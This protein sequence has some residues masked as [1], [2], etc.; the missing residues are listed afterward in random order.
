METTIKRPNNNILFAAIVAA[1]LLP[2]VLFWFKSFFPHNDI[3]NYLFTIVGSLILFAIAFWAIRNDTVSLEEI[4]WT[5]KHL[6]QA[7]WLLFIGWIIFSAIAINF[8]YVFVYPLGDNLQA[9]LLA[10]VQQW[11]FVGL[12]EE[13][14]IRGYILTKVI[15]VF[16][17]KSRFWA[18]IVGLISSSFLFAIFHIPQ[19]IFS[20]GMNLVSYEYLQDV[21]ML[22]ITGILL[23]FVF[24]RTRNVILV[25]LIHGGLNVPLLGE[26]GDFGPMI[27]FIILFEV[28]RWFNKYHNKRKQINNPEKLNET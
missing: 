17:P 6:L 8:N 14:L 25:G 19:R 7:V 20:R 18:N 12:A 28:V 11:F 22:F 21:I 13:L 27:L 1:F 23:G 9:S 26:N 15:K 24:L 10:I 16:S 5:T 3:Y 2:L 4:G